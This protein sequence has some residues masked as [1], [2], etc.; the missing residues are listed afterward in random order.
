M[1]KAIMLYP[2]RCLPPPLPKDPY[3]V[4]FAKEAKG[5]Q[6]QPISVLS[7]ALKAFVLAKKQGVSYV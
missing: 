4:Q 7:L 2:P 5:L 3:L 1:Q 6:G